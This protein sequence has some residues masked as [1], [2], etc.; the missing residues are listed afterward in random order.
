MAVST[1]SVC[2]DIAVNSAFLVLDPERQSAVFELEDNY[3]PEADDADADADGAG[4]DGA[5]ADE[6][7][8]LTAPQNNNDKSLRGIVETNGVLRP[9][10]RAS[11]LGRRL[12]R[13]N[14]SCRP[15][16]GVHFFEPDRIR[17]YALRD[18]EAGEELC[19]TYCDLLQAEADRRR[20]LASYGF[21]CRCPEACG[22]GSAE[23]GNNNGPRR[24]A[25]RRK[26]QDLTRRIRDALVAA[27]EENE[28]DQSS[29]IVIDSIASLF[30]ELDKEG[31]DCPLYGSMYGEIAFEESLLKDD[32]QGAKHWAGV[33]RDAHL[34]ACGEEE[35]SKKG[36]VSNEEAQRLA[37]LA[38]NP[39]T[40]FLDH[41]Q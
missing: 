35:I 40:Y 8:E 25:G 10:D 28:D 31:L 23:G 12:A 36:S 19:L 39:L 7:P 38:L 17:V 15:N 41:D 4:V 6:L 21:R 22:S 9:Y 1:Q 2:D 32:T 29:E 18:V 33:L 3:H 26:L 5:H 11:V 30:E 27:E 37:G 24:D 20:D 14:H 34:W 16:A 13:L